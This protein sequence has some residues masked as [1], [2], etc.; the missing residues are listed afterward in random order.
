M[1]AKQN[2]NS[3]GTVLELKLL[4]EQILESQEKLREGLEEINDK[5]FD[6]DKGLY[7][8]VFKNTEFRT[9]SVKWLWILTTGITFTIA[10]TFIGYLTK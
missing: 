3:P 4:S 5:L 1:S 6:P 10:H 2:K 7:V 8:R 9:I